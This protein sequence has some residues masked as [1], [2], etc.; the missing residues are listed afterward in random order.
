MMLPFRADLPELTPEQRKVERLSKRLN[1]SMPIKAIIERPIEENQSVIKGSQSIIKD[2]YSV[3]K[4]SRSLIDVTDSD[5]KLD[6][7]DDE[8]NIGPTV[9]LNDPIL[10]AIRKF[11]SSPEVLADRDD[12]RRDSKDRS[13]SLYESLKTPTI[14]LTPP[15]PEDFMKCRALSRSQ[16]SL[17]KVLL[18]ETDKFDRQLISKCVVDVL[19]TEPDL[20]ADGTEAVRLFTESARK[21]A[22]YNCIMLEV[23][24][25]KMEGFDTATQIREVELQYHRGRSS[26]I[27]GLCK[28]HDRNLRFMCVQYGMNEGVLKTLEGVKASLL[29]LV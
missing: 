9:A 10:S 13:F 23:S 1:S 29:K 12:V 5:F 19:R 24:L 26:T 28:E 27:I 4:G 17:L 18:V 22:F 25:P 21:G 3:I 16:G 6:I 15:V 11:K 14:I 20:A 8:V 2:S 7:S